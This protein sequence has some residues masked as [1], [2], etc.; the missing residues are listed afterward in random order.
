MNKQT[1]NKISI[2][3]PT[4]LGG[5]AER[6]MVTLANEFD[7]RNILVDLILT[8]AIGQYLADVSLNVRIVN[9]NKKSNLFCI[10]P[11]IRYIRK[12]RPEV[13][14]TALNTTNI[15]A[16]IAKLFSGIS[17]RLVISERAVTSIEMG[18]SNF[19]RAKVISK[20]ISYLYPQADTIVAVSKDVKDDLINIFNIPDTKIEVVYN[21]VVSNKLI[22]LSKEE[23]NNIFFEENKLPFILGVGRLTP[24]KRF[25]TLI[26]AFS[27]IL[28]KYEANLVILG[29]GEMR[30]NLEELANNLNIRDKVFLPGFVNNPFIWMRKASLFVLSSSFEGLPGTLIQAMACGT[31]IVSTDCPG[32]VNEILEQGKWG[33]LAQ[34]GNDK[35]LSQAM[36]LTLKSETHPDITQRAND[37]SV[38]NGVNKYLEVLGLS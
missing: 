25:D 16:I 35:M 28:C 8:N 37:F 15:V 5:G 13:M 2:F 22:E 36:L 27:L 9:L 23:P 24:Q 30:N 33:R 4:L 38:S 3:I 17:F 18:M 11:L 12:E 7:S 34:V 1:H 6:I 10:I 31:P 20:L 32:G 14:L 29:E 21:P 26:K 19:F